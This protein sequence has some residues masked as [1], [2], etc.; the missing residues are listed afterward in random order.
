MPYK[1]KR[2]YEVTKNA[3]Y[4]LMTDLDLM[5]FGRNANVFRPKLI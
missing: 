1:N 5:R 4:G 2:Q 3:I